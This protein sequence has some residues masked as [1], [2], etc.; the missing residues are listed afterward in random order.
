MMRLKQ[1]ITEI[2]ENNLDELNRRIKNVPE[3][4]VLSG[5]NEKIEQRLS[6][7]EE[8]ISKRNWQGKQKS[9]TIPKI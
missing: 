7:M 9:K 8:I 4:K 2:K 5:F 6:N 3:V 1:A